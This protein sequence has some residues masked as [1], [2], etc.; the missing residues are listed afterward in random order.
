MHTQLK[1]SQITWTEKRGPSIYA[2]GITAM[3]LAM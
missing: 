3:D 2:W 1:I